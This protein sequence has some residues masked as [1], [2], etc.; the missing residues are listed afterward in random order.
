ME[1]DGVSMHRTNALL[2]SFRVDKSDTVITV[3]ARYAAVAS[4]ALSDTYH[5]VLYS[6]WLTETIFILLSSTLN[7]LL[8]KLHLSLSLHMNPR[9]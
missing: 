5:V 6:L 4:V 1:T 9:T 2:A 8:F 3:H 7:S